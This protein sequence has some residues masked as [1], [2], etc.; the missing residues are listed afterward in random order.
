MSNLRN[1]IRR[2]SLMPLIGFV[3]GTVVMAN[4]VYDVGPDSSPLQAEMAGWIIHGAFALLALMVLEILR[5]AFL[6]PR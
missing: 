1:V 5:R 2:I 6:G 4:H 3:A